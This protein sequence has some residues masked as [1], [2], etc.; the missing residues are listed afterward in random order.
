MR[1]NGRHTAG[2]SQ[3]PAIRVWAMCLLLLSAVAMSPTTA[4]AAPSQA[5]AATT[6]VYL[7]RGVLNIFSLGLDT[8]GARLEAQGIPV[9]VANFVS[10]SSLANEA[11]TAYRAGRIKTIILVGHSSGATA[12]PDMIAKLNQ[13]GVPVKLA[14]GLDSVFKTRLSTGAERYINIYIGDGP[15]EPV[16][17]AAGLRGKLDNVDVRGT[18]VGHISIDKNEAIQRRVI[19]EIDAAIMRSRA[20]APV[21]EPGAPR[22]ARSAAAAAPRN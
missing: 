3:L 13:L 7:L 8:I 16:R 5:A 10:W 19:A 17:P 11:A 18:G 2:A 9:T 4:R 21:A 6:H 1:P 12:L 20:P 22:Q 15:G 14:I